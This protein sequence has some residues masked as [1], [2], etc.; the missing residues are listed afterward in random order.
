MLVLDG[1]VPKLGSGIR[2]NR[3]AGGGEKRGRMA[4]RMGHPATAA[5]DAEHPTGPSD[6]L[7]LVGVSGATLWVLA[8]V[9]V[10]LPGPL[11]RTLPSL[12][13]LR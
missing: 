3:G 8:W 1:T 9:M 12:P 6:R 11:S 13:W 2:Y 10:Q 7:L 5:P 4:R